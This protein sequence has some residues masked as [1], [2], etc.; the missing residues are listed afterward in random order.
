MKNS[1]LLNPKNVF[2]K[3]KYMLKKS[4]SLCNKIMMIIII[5]TLEKKEG[6]L[7]VQGKSLQLS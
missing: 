5:I 4:T 2:S 7:N 6:T 3:C 1:R